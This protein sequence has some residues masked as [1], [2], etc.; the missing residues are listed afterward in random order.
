[1]LTQKILQVSRAFKE[2]WRTFA[3]TQSVQKRY[4]VLHNY[5]S[6][7]LLFANCERED[8]RQYVTWDALIQCLSNGITKNKNVIML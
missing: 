7:I 4:V 8:K 1:M 3:E 5:N 2:V 6:S